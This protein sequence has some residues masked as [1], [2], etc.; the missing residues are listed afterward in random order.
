MSKFPSPY[1]PP[2]ARWYSRSYYVW[3]AAKNLFHFESLTLPGR[4][5]FWQLTLSLI[6][7]GY[8]FYA[9]RR[10]KIG[11]A[12]QLGY[13]WAALVFVVWLG[14]AAANL[15]IGAMIALHVISVFFLIRAWDMD[16]SF[17]SRLL[18]ALGTLLLVGLGLYLPLRR[19]I[20]R[21][22]IM[23]FRV[24]NRVVV[25]NTF[26]QPSAIHRGD[27]IAYKMDRYYAGNVLI[28]AGYVLG[29]VQAVAG[30]RVRITPEYVQVNGRAAPRL[31]HMP[32]EAEYTVPEKHW[33]IW[34]DLRI[35]GYGAGA[36]DIA[37]AFAENA[38]VP[39]TQFVG[40]P[41]QRWFWRRQSDL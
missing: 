33:F 26:K 23:P 40:R 11:R 10:Q 41:F 17:R 16:W 35:S 31:A 38:L 19:Q 1:Y 25:V 4:M 3:L 27:W 18:L 12:I 5:A 37:R 20:E 22:L 36:G 34:P 2:R 13:G 6:L 32:A 21:Q 15:A 29:R 28:A 24:G 9:L 30:D 7:P 14:Y 8:S 39:E